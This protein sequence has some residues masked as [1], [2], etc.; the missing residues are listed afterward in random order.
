M[1]LFCGSVGGHR[2]KKKMTQGWNEQNC[3]MTVLIKEQGKEESIGAVLFP[4]CFLRNLTTPLPLLYQKRFQM[5]AVDFQTTKRISY[6]SGLFG[7]VFRLSWTRKKTKRS[8]CCKAKRS[9]IE[10]CLPFDFAHTAAATMY[11]LTVWRAIREHVSQ[12]RI[13]LKKSFKLSVSERRQHYTVIIYLTCLFFCST[14][15]GRKQ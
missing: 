5:S 10:V 15:V 3:L 1:S 9:F 6:Q 11:W 13:L 4:R 12:L 7:F 14:V 2:T 8:R